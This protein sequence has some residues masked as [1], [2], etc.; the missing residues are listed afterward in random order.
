M[1]PVQPK[2]RKSRKNFIMISLICVSLAVLMIP[3]AFAWFLN[4]RKASV[5][6]ISAQVMSAN[7]LVMRAGN[8]EWSKELTVSASKDFQFRAVTGNGVSFYAPVI[9]LV[10]VGSTAEDIMEDYAVT[11]LTPMPEN[12][13]ADSLISY[14]F[15]ARIEEKH[16]LC[17]HHSS[18]SRGADSKDPRDFASAVIRMALLVKEGDSY[19]TVLVWIPDVTSKLVSDEK[20]NGSITAEQERGITLMDQNGNDLEIAV[21]GESGSRVIDGINYVWGDIDEEIYVTELQPMEEK[22]L[23]LVIWVDG[24]DRDCENPMM[25]ANVL[26]TLNFTAVEMDE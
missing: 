12:E 2:G 5:E 8:G 10:E 23:R 26:V 20:G 7:N 17:L 14:D 21:E 13:W 4:V 9:E 15:S 6:G 18:V 3:A 24:R 22:D 25:S 1:E 16:T 19:R 11:G